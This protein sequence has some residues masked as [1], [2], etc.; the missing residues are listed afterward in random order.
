[1]SFPWL[2]LHNVSV[3]KV[4]SALTAFAV[5]VGVMT[6]VA[7]GVVTE[8]VRTTAA[9]VLHVGSADFTV[10]QRNVSDIL[11]SSL[12]DGQ[13]ARVATVPGVRSA[14]GVL[15]DTEKLDDAHPLLVEI[16]I[17]PEDLT[18]FGV[19]VVAGQPFAA[20]APNEVMLGS[21]LA[22]DLNTRIG[23]TINIAGGPKK[24]VGI[25]STGNVFGD[26][27]TMFPL[28]PFQA[29]ERQPGGLSLLFVKVDPKAKADVA[30]VEKRVADSSPVLAPIR[31][32]VEFGRADRDYQLITAADRAATIVAIAI[33]AIIVANTMLLSLVERYRE[34]GIL[35]AV[36][37]SR[38]RVIG[39]VLGEALTIGFGGAVIGVGIAYVLI[40][41]LARLPD[42]EGILQPTY[43]AGVFGRALFTAAAVAFLG[44]LYPALRAAR[45]A[46]LEAIRRE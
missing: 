8:S 43:N 39:L 35:R 36:G 14:V 22:A 19:R 34:F 12:T 26:S 7:L 27:A 25:Y 10:A 16:G 4:R 29:F 41:I 37:W 18:P 23:Q 33:G 46:P 38:R 9:G 20:N 17:R 13:L 28:V 2:I 1:M 42:L 30:A 5:A 6:V 15:L 3:K 40:R 11:E 24:I 45:L 31:N 44:A 21:R 32:L